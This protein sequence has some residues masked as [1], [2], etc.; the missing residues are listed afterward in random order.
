MT[1]A[2]WGGPSCSPRL[3]LV[4]LRKKRER[5]DVQN[6]DITLSKR[7]RL[8]SKRAIIP[9]DDESLGI[10]NRDF[11]R[12]RGGA[13]PR[14][15]VENILRE[16]E[17]PWSRC[18]N[19]CLGRRD[20]C[21]RARRSIRLLLKRGADSTVKD[22]DGSTLLQNKRQQRTT[23]WVQLLSRNGADVDAKDDDTRTPLA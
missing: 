22:S 19:G 14:P 7:A 23:Q 4:P 17:R 16:E 10:L 18:Y 13:I 1:G 3:C 5:K 2:A 12:K 20:S 21:E 6:D 15:A 8:L 9:I 11:S